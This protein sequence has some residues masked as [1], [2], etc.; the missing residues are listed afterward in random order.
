MS[1][2]AKQH[3]TL[4]DVKKSLDRCAPL[5]HALGD[6]NRQAILLLLAE[7]ERLNVS[8]IS[9]RVS[10]SRPTVS[11][12]LKVLKEAGLISAEKESRE[13]YYTLVWDEPIGQLKTLIE[14]AEVACS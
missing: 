3:W 11:H 10:F 2:A 6:V 12:H 5:F 8:E 7:F 14:Q 1:K 4:K 13:N 9:E